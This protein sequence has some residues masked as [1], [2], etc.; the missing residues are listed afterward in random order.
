M[1]QTDSST[2]KDIS[3]LLSSEAQYV[4]LT[5]MTQRFDLSSFNCVTHLAKSLL[6]MGT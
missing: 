3:V 4:S 1:R 2:Q 5:L 6:L